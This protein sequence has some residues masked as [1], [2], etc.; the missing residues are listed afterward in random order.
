[1]SRGFSEFYNPLL[2]EPA[3]YNSYES[4]AKLPETPWSPYQNDARAQYIKETQNN[5]AAFLG[6]IK[7]N[8]MGGR[9]KLS[10]PEAMPK[11]IDTP[12]AKP[13][14]KAYLFSLNITVESLLMFLLI[15]A[16]V[17]DIVLRLRDSRSPVVGGARYYDH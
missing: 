3:G 11:P 6:G 8:L 2:S 9:E 12:P 14:D 5:V 15:V 10:Q 13:E 7:Q 16:L 17:V 1:M 4:I